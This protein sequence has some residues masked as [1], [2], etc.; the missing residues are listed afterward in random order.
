VLEDRTALSTTGIWDVVQVDIPHGLNA[1]QAS[2][3]ISLSLNAQVFL[4]QFGLAA[5][6]S[7]H[8]LFEFNCG[9]LYYQ[10]THWGPQN[11]VERSMAQFAGGQVPYVLATS[12]AEAAQG[13][14]LWEETAFN[15]GWWFAEPPGDNRSTM[16]SGPQYGREF[17]APSLLLVDWMLVTGTPLWNLEGQG[18][19]FLME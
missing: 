14:L 17:Q 9:D 15:N 3:F 6:F 18:G 4:S 8:R 12:Q 19:A 13:G 5:P 2:L 1:A 11:Q 10:L 7:P 16:P